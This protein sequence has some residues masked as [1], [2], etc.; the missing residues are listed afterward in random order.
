MACLAAH[1]SYNKQ[2]N[3]LIDK[4]GERFVDKMRRERKGAAKCLLGEPADPNGPTGEDDLEDVL[5][6]LEAPIAAK[7]D[8]GAVHTEQVYEVFYH[9]IRLYFLASK[10]YVDK[11]REEEKQSAAYSG[12]AEPFAKTSELELKKMYEAALKKGEQKKFTAKDYML[13][14][15]K[16]REY[17]R[18]EAR[19]RT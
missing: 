11:Y 19:L 9:W 14:K 12:L 1:N 6:F 15:E 10:S 18:A 16:I 3:A 5:D 13:S 4:Y 8:A 17:L 2:S 7:L